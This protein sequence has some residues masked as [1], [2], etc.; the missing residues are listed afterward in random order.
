MIE[1]TGKYNKA[2]VMI[3]EIDEETNKQI[4]LFLECP[5]FAGCYIVIMPDVH[6]GKGAVVGFTSTFNKY[7]I[8]NVIGVDIGCGIDAYNT[9]QMEVNFEDFDKFIRK[10]IPSGFDIHKT[11]NHL[12]NVKS[13]L[14]YSEDLVNIS[15]KLGIEHEK[16]LKSLGTLGGGNH[17]IEL[18]KDETGR[19]WLSIHTGSRNFGLRIANYHQAKA[20]DNFRKVYGKDNPYPNLE[21]LLLEEEDG[22]EYLK[23]MKVAQRFAYLNRQIIANTILEGYFGRTQVKDEVESV[24]SIH[25]Y[26]DFRDKVIRKGAISA[27]EGEKVIIPLNMCDGVIIGTGK[28]NSKWNSSAPHGAG[29]IMSRTKAKEVLELDKFKETMTGI[30]SSCITLETLDEAPAAYKD[31]ELIKKAIKDTVDID[32]IMKPVYNFKAV[33]EDIRKKK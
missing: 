18:D 4:L 33:E 9:E 21:W 6:A 32:F 23:D 10:N 19:L 8:C 25:N 22:Q 16:V 7:I 13:D 29:R 14:L 12:L 28:G 26:M 11:T 17:F 27:R 15:K 3:D 1:I 2:F 31:A 24:K 30:W 5:A 20:K